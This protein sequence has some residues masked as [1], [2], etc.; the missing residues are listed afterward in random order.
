MATDVD[1]SLYRDVIG[2]FASG[3]TVVTTTAA[4]R[5]YGTT[6]SAVS[7]LSA[8]PPMLL[9]CLNR[10]S[11]TQAAIMETKRFVVNVLAENQEEVAKRFATKSANKFLEDEILRSPHGLPL[12]PGALA[13]LEC[14]VAETA[15]GGTHTVFLSE[16]ERAEASDSGPLTYYRGRFGRFD[17]LVQ[18]STYRD[19]RTMV[20]RRQLPTPDPFDVHD[21]ATALGMESA[22]VLYAL[23][24][25][26][27]DGLI[28]RDL[29]GLYS[30]RPMDIR[31]A[32]Q[33]LEA[34]CAIQIAVIDAL[35]QRPIDEKRLD[36]LQV[37]VE[38]CLRSVERDPPD[39]HLL[40][41]ASGRFQLALAG[42]LDNE[43]LVDAYRRLGIEGIWLRALGAD[44][45]SPLY[46]VDLM[47]ALRAG[48]TEAAKRVI[49][50]F[51]AE[52]RRTAAAAISR[53]GGAL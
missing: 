29:N 34:C 37:H 41:A 33:A 48:D 13:H 40:R 3:V 22:T 5:D 27:S 44:Y 9:I 12:V 49:Y 43:L 51:T 53:A 11:E 15:A 46:L 28:E 35:G 6:A 19:I 36:E 45:L 24:K 26:I 39:L 10:T 38:E 47:A 7:S 21:L 2:R 32:D 16:V 14:S 17:E 23:T 18:E 4:Q 20:I 52:G 50:E 1:P 25:L 31:L 30:I 42:V 8:E